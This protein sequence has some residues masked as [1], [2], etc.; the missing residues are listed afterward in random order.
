MSSSDDLHDLV[1]D[2]TAY[3]TRLTRK[4]RDR[5]ATVLPDHRR[6]KAVIPGLIVSL[7]VEH[8]QPVRRG[9]ALVVLEAMKMRNS[10]TATADGSVK[11]IHVE[12]GALVAKGD[13]LVEL[14]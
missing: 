1:I 7:L 2:D 8:G 13:L 4:F 3:R 11:R 6:V 14:E 10:I 12:E 9:D 5:K